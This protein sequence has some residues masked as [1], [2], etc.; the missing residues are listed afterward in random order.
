MPEQRRSGPPAA[1]KPGRTVSRFLAVAR[2]VFSSPARRT[3]AGLLVLLFLFLLAVNGLDVA[4]SYVGRDFMSALAERRTSRFVTLAGAYAGLFALTTV[5][6]VFYRFAEERLGLLWREWMTADLIRQYLAGRVYLR[7]HDGGRPDNP[8]QRISEDVRTFTTSA[9][10]LLLIASNSAV[11]LVAFSGV[12]WSITPWLMAAS[13][14]YAALGTAATLVAGRRLPGLNFEQFRREAD[15]RFGLVRVREHA[16]AIALMAGEEDERPRLLRRLSAAVE[17]MKAVI[18]VNRNVGFFTTGYGYLTPLVPVLVTA[19]LYLRGDAEF[20]TV[21]QSA[22]AFGYVLGAFSLIV[23][24]FQ[25]LAAFK[26]VTDRLGELRESAG[27]QPATGGIELSETAGHRIAF[28]RLTVTTPTCSVLIRDLTLEIPVGRRV[29]IRGPNGA[30]RTA[31]VRAVAGLR[32]H[33]TGRIVRPPAEDIL[34]LPQ[35]PYLTEG[36]LREQ[37]VY[38]VKTPPPN[39]A[40]MAEVLRQARLGRV[41]D[42]AAGDLDTPAD[43]PAVLSQGEQQALAFARLLLAAPAFAVLDEATGALD[44]DSTRTLYDL[45]ARSQ[46]TYVRAG[47]DPALIEFHDQA[48]ELRPDGG[49]ALSPCSSDRCQPPARPAGPEPLPAGR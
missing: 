45:L 39:D 30:G 36:T 22:V 41:L 34:F 49:W 37:L 24:Q 16:D 44:A 23:A 38:G 10:S 19:P 48:L 33:G 13:L 47:N 2:P 35:R 17:N 7:I 18:A 29:L 12:L 6:A 26:A 42:R 43:W 9:L 14:A 5:V 15:L 31:L 1:L 40:R 32:S 11:A 20:G 3:V 25:Q 21:T 46:I 4:A 27:E 8:D 28:E